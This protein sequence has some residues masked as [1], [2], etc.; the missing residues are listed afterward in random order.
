[1]RAQKQTAN[2]VRDL[3]EVLVCG[4]ACIA[5]LL[6]RLNPDQGTWR[7]TFVCSTLA[8]MFLGLAVVA[9]LYP[10]KLID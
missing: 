7:V 4:A 5:L 1:M 6:V 10:R 3:L 8:A 2:H 9:R